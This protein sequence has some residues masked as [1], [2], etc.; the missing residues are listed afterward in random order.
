M[1]I[2]DILTKSNYT[3]GAIWCNSNNAHIEKQNGQYIIVANTIPT[4]EEI[5]AQAIAELNAEY[6]EAKALYREYYVNALMRN[7]SELAQ[8]I[9][10]DDVALDTEY[11]T[12]LAELEG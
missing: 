5:K 1:N 8:S 9:A 2:E 4:Q 11:D 12:Q 7:D 10:D 6:D 3:D